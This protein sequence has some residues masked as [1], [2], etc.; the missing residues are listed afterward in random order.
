MGEKVRVEGAGHYYSEGR[1]LLALWTGLLLPPIAWVVNFET[2]YALVPGLC[3]RGA[4]N[5]I[6]WLV[7]GVS[8]VASLGA[9]L[10]AWSCYQDL[11]GDAMQV[12]ADRA[13]T[14]AIG[15]VIMSALFTLAIV[16]IA[17]PTFM[18]RP[19]E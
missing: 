1:G 19:C 3:G 15:G 6:L 16:G 11:R 14:M 13:R 12:D 10:L 17:V 7:C 9:G 2:N 18:L 8:M 4:G 5:A